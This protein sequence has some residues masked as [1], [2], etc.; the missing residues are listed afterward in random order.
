MSNDLIDL[1]AYSYLANFQAR[2]SRESNDV[3]YLRCDE[4]HFAKVLSHTHTTTIFYV[5][6]IRTKRMVKLK[7]FDTTTDRRKKI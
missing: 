6:C 4:N 3:F 7:R 1:Y 5:N 2:N